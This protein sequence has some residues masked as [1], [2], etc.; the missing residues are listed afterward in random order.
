M[1]VIQ[2]ILNAPFDEPDSGAKNL[3]QYF[4]ALLKTLF[5]EE[6]GFSGKRP[7]GNSGWTWDLAAQ[8]IQ[9]G[10][11]Y[12]TYS[13]EDGPEFSQQEFDHLINDA[14]EAL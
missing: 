2:V 9:A 4:K 8:L 1:N 12:G 11:L 6:E 13:D 14:I 3:R 7:F 10:V 5:E